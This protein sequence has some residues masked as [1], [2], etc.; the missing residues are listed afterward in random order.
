[1]TEDEVR[2]IAKMAAKEAVHETF[3]S[4]GLDPDDH[5]GAQRDFQFMRDLRLSA[6]T[7]K[8]QGLM[9]AVGILVTGLLALVGY[10]IF[11]S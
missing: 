3:V 1:M 7:V 5:A 6:E 8:R 2:G 10:A 11:K 9:T 4:L